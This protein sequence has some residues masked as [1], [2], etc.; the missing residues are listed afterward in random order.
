MTTLLCLLLSLWNGPL[1]PKAEAIHE[2]WYL[3]ADG[4]HDDSAAMR[5]IM[6]HPESVPFAKLQPDGMWVIT[7]PPGGFI[8]VN[9]ILL[10]PNRLI[11]R[12]P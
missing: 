5:F 11:R 4:V 12:L 9:N 7:L 6:N 1:L 2:P 10:Q 3:Y 8:V